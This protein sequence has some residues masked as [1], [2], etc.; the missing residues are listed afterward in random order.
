L[1]VFWSEIETTDNPKEIETKMLK[2]FIESNIPKDTEGE[3]IDKTEYYP[4]AN[5]VGPYGFKKHELTFKRK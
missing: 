2:A 5:K 1:D 3:P 4:F